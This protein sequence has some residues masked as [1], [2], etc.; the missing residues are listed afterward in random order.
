MRAMSAV[1]S[2][3]VRSSAGHYPVQ[4]EA[5][6]LSTLGSR[7]RSAAVG[8]RIALVADRTVAALYAEVARQSLIDAGYETALLQIDPGEAQKS[9]V[10]AER[11]YSGLVRK[12]FGR[13]DT[14]VALGGGV[15]GDLAGFVAATFHR[16]MAFVQVPTTLLAQVDSSIGGK[17][18]V[19]L[20]EGKNLVGAFHPPKLV[21]SDVRVLSTLP[22][23]ERWCGLAE[24][25][26]TALILD[27]DL[28]AL[29]EGDLEALAAGTA[30]EA[31]LTAVVAR[32]AQLKAEVV[33]A[34]E[35]ERGP[36]L[37]LN[38]GHTVG[39]A[40]ETATGHGPLAHGEAVVLGM[41][42]AV[43]LS[44][45]LGRL[46]EDK[47]ARA[48]GL[49]ARFPLPVVPPPHPDDIRAALGRDKKAAEGSVRFIVLNDL[50][51]A[52]VERSVA[53]PLVDEAISAALERMGGR[54]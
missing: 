20:A 40:L 54:A 18:A 17:V 45:R 32:T 12:G 52:Q 47:A 48:R 25:V 11:L 6:A 19:D 5:G 44:E 27:G 28:F 39:H 41:F 42:A 10:G 26:K 30:S 14:V 53:G 23:R 33:S 38:F 43:R 7:C 36:R 51:A 13:H 22:V 49:L 46:P 9:L 37:L 8:G 2:L 29:L 50:G 1:E 35:L 21:V 4:V 31:Q 15:V 3:V 24:A 34:D 16:G